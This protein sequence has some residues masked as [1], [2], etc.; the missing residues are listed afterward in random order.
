VVGDR[1]ADSAGVALFRQNATATELAG[2]AFESADLAPIPGFAGVPV[3]LLVAIDPNGSFLD[4]AVLS[5]HE[6]V[7]LDGLGEHRCSPRAQYLGW[8]QT[9]HNIDSKTKARARPT[10]ATPT[11]GI[12][13][14]P[15][16]C[17]SSTRAGCCG[18]PG[19]RSKLG[20]ARQRPGP[21]ARINPACSSD[22]GALLDAG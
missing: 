16:R 9:A 20:L 22:G 3:N 5:H 8:P 19:R 2:Y 1:Q 15:R 17:A 13:R 21:P 10:P 12:R 14:R 6:P 18:A 11:D 7:F 4:A